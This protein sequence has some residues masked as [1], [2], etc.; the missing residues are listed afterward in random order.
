MKVVHTLKPIYNHES[1]VLI[2]G[3]MPSV[4]S[5]EVMFYYGHPKNRFWDV[6]SAVYEEEKPLSNEDKTNFL[7]RHKIALYDVLKSC[8]IIASYDSSI[9]NPVPNDFTK[10]LKVS[11]IKVIFTTGRKATELYK[12]YCY[13]QT[14]IE[15]IMLPSTSSAN[16]KL[17]MK[18]LYDNYYQI[19]DITDNEN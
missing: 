18:D 2:L 5:R 19:R 1:K 12:K 11:N 16:C 4:K 13:A 10:I 6:L 8:D 9:K 17:S 15:A 14:K 7:L 3:T